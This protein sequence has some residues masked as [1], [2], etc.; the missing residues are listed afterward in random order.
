MLFTRPNRVAAA[1]A[2]LLLLLAIPA[3]VIALQVM[4]QM[5]A[6]LQTGAGDSAGFK[7]LHGLSMIIYCGE[8]LILLIVVV[9]LPWSLRLTPPAPGRA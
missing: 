7:R 8:A 1:S 5:N 4:P 6:L 2:V 9:L 3:A